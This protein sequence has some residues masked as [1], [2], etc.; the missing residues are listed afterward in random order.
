MLQSTVH[1]GGGGGGE[2]CMLQ[3]FSYSSCSSSFFRLYSTD[4]L[5]GVFCR[6]QDGL[7]RKGERAQPRNRNT[8]AV[9]NTFLTLHVVDSD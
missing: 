5:D 1:W 8:G 9:S 3:S 6:I 7:L 2:L 4:L